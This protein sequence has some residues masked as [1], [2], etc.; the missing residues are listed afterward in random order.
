MPASIKTR[1]LK[2][3][4]RDAIEQLPEDCTAEDIH[5]RLYL[6]EKIRRGEASLGKVAISH[7]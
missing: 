3:Q 4:V 7:A 5:Y 6:I 2:D 1:S